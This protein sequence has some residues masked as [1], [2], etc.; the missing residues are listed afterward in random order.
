MQN[1]NFSGESGVGDVS[2]GPTGQF[3]STH[4]SVVLAA[5]G[6]E[7][8][9]ARASLEELCRTYWHPVFAHVRRL[10]HGL[11]DA[12]DL[13]QD[14]FVRLIHK[15]ALASVDPAKGRFRSFLLAA[16]K[17]FLANEWDKARAQKRGGGRVALPLDELLEGNAGC[18]EPLDSMTAERAFDYRWALT[19]LEGTLKRL[20][21]QY[22]RDGKAS[23][24]EGLKA[25]LG[26]ESKSYAELAEGLGMSVGAVKVAV[27]RMRQ[28]YREMLRA[29][30]AQT[31]A[32]SDEV[33]DEMRALFA[34]LRGS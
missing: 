17:H 25:A 30:I 32:S 10:G 22:E 7:S 3:A 13:T 24:F 28:R 27:S 20:R 19:V 4:W 16:L 2:P 26:G 33:E 6:S 5:R 31:V 1:E 34:A 11:D 12:K 29:E 15:G 8:V 9:S 21:E 18:A 23:V 14:F